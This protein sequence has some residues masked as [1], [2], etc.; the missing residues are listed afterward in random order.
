[1]PDIGE[2][3]TPLRIVTWLVPVLLLLALLAIYLAAPDFYLAYVLEESRREYQAVEFVTVGS[4]LIASLILA[5]CAV[6]LW[7]VGPSAFAPQA[8]RGRFAGRSGA[9]AIGVIAL[10]AFFFGGEEMSWGQT[11]FGWKTPEDYRQVSVETNLHNVDFPI[12][13]QSIGS[14]F[15]FTVLVILPALWALRGRIGLTLPGEWGP[16]MAEP[17]VI[18]AIVVAFAWKLFKNGYRTLAGEESTFYM[19]FVE[20]INEQKEMLVAV[21][22]L[23]YALHRVVAVRDVSKV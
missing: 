6:R 4:A 20:Q 1:M 13:V 12:S 22:L 15:I 18:F 3:G 16:A 17:P 23:L 19:Q 9:I 8:G 21:G 2:R 5:G 7:R 11:Y 10:A 14:A